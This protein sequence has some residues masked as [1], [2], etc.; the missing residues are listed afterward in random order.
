MEKLAFIYLEGNDS[1]VTVFEKDKDTLKL[2]KA[3]S[4]SAAPALAEKQELPNVMDSYEQAEMVSF[5]PLPGEGPSDNGLLQSLNKALKE[6]DLKTIK[7]VPILTEPDVHFKKLED[8]KELNTL[9]ASFSGKGKHETLEIVEIA[10]NSKLAVYTSGK[11]LYL[12]MMNSLARMNSFRYLKIASV[13]CAEVSLSGYA[14]QKMNLEEGKEI[15]LILYIGKEYSKLIFMKGRKIF[16]IGTTVTAGKNSANS[17]YVIM[18][19]ILL[20]MENAGVHELNRIIICGED[21]SEELISELKGSYPESEITFLEITD[22]NIPESSYSI[23]S[24]SV[25]LAAAEEYLKEEEKKTRGINLL[26]GYIAEEQK[27]FGWES[28]VLFLAIFL[29]VFLFTFLIMNNNSQIMKL[30]KE[31][32]KYQKFQ[33]EN[34]ELI[35]KLEAKKTLL[36]NFDKSKSVLESYSKNTDALSSALEKISDYVYAQDNIWFTFLKLDMDRSLKLSGYGLN[37]RLLTQF[38]Y[39]CQDALLNDITYEPLRNTRAYKFNIST[40]AGNS[41]KNSTIENMGSSK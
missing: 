9:K 22:F 41:I 28:Y 7:F 40:T 2:I 10:D 14:A 35:D 37:R 20:E 8:E 24:F 38:S 11:S 21:S 30:D 34:Q 32:I 12:Q 5:E 31:I 29:A 26:P 23:S 33:I 16:F 6:F 3:E 15:S 25:N 39:S 13:K 1:K 4:L 18:S 36:A 17:Y 27:S 19:K